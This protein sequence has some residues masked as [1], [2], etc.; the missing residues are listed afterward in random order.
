MFPKASKDDLLLGRRMSASETRKMSTLVKRIGRFHAPMLK[1]QRAYTK[2]A[3]TYKY[4][5][6]T[7]AEPP[8]LRKKSKDMFRCARELIAAG[9]KVYN[10]K[11]TL[12]RKYK[13]APIADTYYAAEYIQQ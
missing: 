10:Y 12:K 6:G 9:K 11:N 2:A 13:M 5:D 8:A 4:K 3:R 1:A 7:M